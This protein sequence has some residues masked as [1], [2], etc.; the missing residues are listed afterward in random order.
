MAIDKA[1]LPDATG[2]KTI[3]VT[4]S[5][6][7][8]ALTRPGNTRLMLFNAGPYTVFVEFGTGST[9]AAVATGYPIGAG[10]KEILRVADGTTHIACISGT[11]GSTLYV[12]TGQGI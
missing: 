3:S 11:A 12:T 2:T 9:T 1:W 8:T 10:Q 6:A 7:A 5:S 4:A